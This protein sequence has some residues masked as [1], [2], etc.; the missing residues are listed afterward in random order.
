MMEDVGMQDV[1][2][3]EVRPCCFDFFF[4]FFVLFLFVCVFLVISK[5]MTVIIT[6]YS[7]TFKEY[8]LM[9]FCIIE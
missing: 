6:V 7:Y 4:L 9:G 2:F 3:N 1:H 5:L 8:N